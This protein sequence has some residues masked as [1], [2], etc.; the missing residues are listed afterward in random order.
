MSGRS[1]P[2]NRKS[3]K[4]RSRSRSANRRVQAFSDHFSG[5]P[6]K[7]INHVFL[8]DEK[9]RAISVRKANSGSA[10]RI[11]GRDANWEK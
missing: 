8:Y 6:N 5:N 1:R 7:P 3:S 11:P 2:K 10:S 9:P 4:S